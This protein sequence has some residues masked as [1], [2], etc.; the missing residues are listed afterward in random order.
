MKLKYFS[1][2]QLLFSPPL[3]DSLN[4]LPD[5]ALSSLLCLGLAVLTL[6]VLAYA[7][8]SVSWNSGDHLARRFRTIFGSVTAKI[9]M[10]SASS[11]IM[12]AM[13]GLTVGQACR[14]FICLHVF[15]AFDFLMYLIIFPKWRNLFF[16]PC[17]SLILFSVV[18]PSSNF[19]EVLILHEILVDS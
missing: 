19:Q 14:K 8:H 7:L 13:S 4:G 11:S 6:W 10:Q 12:L 16:W 18:V 15:H 1:F 5:F 17:T 3:Q 2:Y 9:E